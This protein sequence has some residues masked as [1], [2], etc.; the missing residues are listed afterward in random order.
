M[1]NALRKP[2]LLCFAGPNGSGKS[3]ITKFFEIAGEYTNADDVVSSTGM[4]N[5]E[6]AKF[7]DKKRY[8]SIEAKSDLTFET[9]LSSK[10]KMDILRK[11][12]AEGYFIK[13][14]FVLT[15]DP[16]LNV[17]RVESRVMQGGHDV[18]R[19]KVKTRFYKSLANIKELMSLCDIL[20]VY[21][22]TD[23]PY[24]IIR[25]H[26]DSIT[27]F[28]NEYWDEE[29]IIALITGTYSQRYIG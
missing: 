6:A 9:V 10:Y 24:R 29:D 18:D 22:N 16:E 7:V 3:T 14:V 27:I 4:E 13:C 8:D 17:S 2:M 1:D 12:K 11:S 28:P 19:E 20:H 23:T 26:K 21:D 5:E 25:K 15:A